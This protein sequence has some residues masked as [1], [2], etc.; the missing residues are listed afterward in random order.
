MSYFPNSAGPDIGTLVATETARVYIGSNDVEKGELVPFTAYDGSQDNDTG[1]W[2]QV[3]AY[4]NNKGFERFWGV[5]SKDVA[6]G[7]WATLTV[8]GIVQVK[9]TGAESRLTGDPAA[10]ANAQI[11]VLQP[12]TC[13]QATTT[14]ATPAYKANSGEA[15]IAQPVNQ[16]T[17]IQVASGETKMVWC[18]VEGLCPQAMV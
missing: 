3:Q 16:S 7:N 14:T 1:H 15:M 17:A 8:R 4:A 5:A 12:L 6:S 13:D 11:V 9:V 2:R 18:L 10:R